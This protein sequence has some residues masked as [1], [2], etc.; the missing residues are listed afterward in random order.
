MRF[1]KLRI[2][3]SLFCGLLCLLLI[4]LWLT[5]Y[6]WVTNIQ[7]PNV[8]SRNFQ[9]VFS[10]GRICFTSERF[11]SGGNQWAGEFRSYNRTDPLFVGFSGDQ[12]SPSFDL[13]AGE[14]KPG[15]LRIVFPYWFAS[16]IFAALSATP[17]MPRRF[18]VRTL[19][20]A[21]TL[22]AVVLGLAASSLR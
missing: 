20:I 10:T 19:L 14:I 6:W 4:V 3:W 2:A 11:I 18:G 9:L 13:V 21:T 12:F 5:S 1:R 7:V 16:M 17:L 22:V 15:D 8:A